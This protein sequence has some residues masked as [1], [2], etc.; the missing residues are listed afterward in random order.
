MDPAFSGAGSVDLL[1][2]DLEIELDL[3]RQDISRYTEEESD[4]RKFRTED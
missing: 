3:E 4:A 1:E 2:L